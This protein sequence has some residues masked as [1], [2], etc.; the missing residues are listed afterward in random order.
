ME[1]FRHLKY[2]VFMVLA[3]TGLL[4]LLYLANKRKI[5][6]TA[7]L[8]HKKLL[9]KLIPV[10]TSILRKIK[11]ILFITAF[12]F[13][14]IAWALP[15]W[16][17]EFTSQTSRLGQVIIAVDSSL[18]ML[19]E[20]IK[21]SRI[22]NAKTMFK[23]LINRL[24]GYR[25]GIIA[26][27]GEAYVQCPITTDIDALKYFISQINA[28][29]LP[30]QGTSLAG[31]L[32]LASSML[33]K[34]PG[35]KALILLTDGEDH[36]K[37]ELKQALEETKKAQVAVFT[38]GI[39]NAKGGL[40]PADGGFKTDEKN[41]PVVSRLDEDA[42][43]NIAAKTGGAYIRYN[44]VSSVAGEIS[45]QLENL[46]KT[47]WEGKT[48]SIYKNRYQIPLFIAVI[49]LLLELIIPERKYRLWKKR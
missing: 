4:V 2:L 38:I 40:I 10:E 47:K 27:A 11:R 44:D 12:G 30:V 45:A 14:F 19:V 9:A 36:N 22:E 21:P 6:L 20:D 32:K 33:S 25:M 48:R 37:P 46:T 16:G 39:G 29:A 28:G 13:I 49:L 5:A 15:Q 18:S 26:F 7:K 41:N 8:F 35:Q 43:I 31:P 34:Y 23:V 42:L 3:V 1:L 24:A 17:V